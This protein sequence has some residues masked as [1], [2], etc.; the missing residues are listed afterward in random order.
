MWNRI[1]STPWIGCFVVAGICIGLQLSPFGFIFVFLTFYPSVFFLNLG[2][3][4]LTIEGFRNK[5]PRW[6]L[7]V[8]SIWFGGYYAAALLSNGM[9]MK[10]DHQ[11]VKDNATPIEWARSTPLLVIGENNFAS[12][13]VTD[14][15]LD[16]AFMRDSAG[17]EDTSRIRLVWRDCSHPLAQG[18]T[19][20]LITDGGYGTGRPFR[21]AKELCTDYDKQGP[22]DTPIQIA[23]APEVFGKGL[24]EGSTQAVSITVPG[25]NPISLMTAGP[26]WTLPWIPMLEIGCHLKGGFGDSWDKGCSIEFLKRQKGGAHRDA[27]TVVTKA[28]GLREMATKDRFPTLKWHCLDS[29]LVGHSPPPASYCTHD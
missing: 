7:I 17:N 2:F 15:G 5:L 12:T 29:V 10:L 9:A 27:V 4:L 22:S 13:F 3:V 28:L 21:S 8:P 19:F 1:F 24:V 18:A 6:S 16:E 23:V 26:R 11:L 20:H 14:Y 25:H